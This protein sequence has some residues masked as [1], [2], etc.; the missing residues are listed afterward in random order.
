MGLMRTIACVLAAFAAMVPVGA[1][2]SEGRPSSGS[3]QD[4]PPQPARITQ[5][6]AKKW[7]RHVEQSLRQGDPSVLAA[8]IDGDAIL[9]AALA[10]INAPAELKRGYADRVKAR[11]PF[12]PKYAERIAGDASGDDS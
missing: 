1:P 4:R 7:A 8:A 11:N 9:K 5:E 10:G 6:E 2:A 12:G 3:P